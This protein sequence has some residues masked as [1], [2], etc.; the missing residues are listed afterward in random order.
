[1]QTATVVNFGLIALMYRFNVSYKWF[2][3][4]YEDKKSARYMDICLQ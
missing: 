1:M 2:L 3:N 4:I